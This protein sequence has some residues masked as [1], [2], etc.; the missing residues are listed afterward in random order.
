MQITADISKI[1]KNVP[2]DLTF[3]YDALSELRI[4]FV[5][6]LVLLALENVV[7]FTKTSF[8]RKRSSVTMRNYMEKFHANIGLNLT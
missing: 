5:S 6:F 2:S 3:I 7:S 1:L 4:G 8:Y